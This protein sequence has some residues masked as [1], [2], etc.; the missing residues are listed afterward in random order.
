MPGFPVKQSPRV[1]SLLSVLHIFG[2]RVSFYCRANKFHKWLA[3][4]AAVAIP[5]LDALYLGTLK[6]RKLLILRNG[7]REKDHKNTEPRY[8]PGKWAD[9]EIRSQE[10]AQPLPRVPKS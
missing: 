9:S 7:K 2:C 8:T 10:S 6:M 1:G 3:F 4:S 5:R